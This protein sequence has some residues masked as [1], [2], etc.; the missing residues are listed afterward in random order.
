MTKT[1]LRI[2]ACLFVALPIPARA[3]VPVDCVDRAD[4]VNAFRASNG[5]GPFEREWAAYEERVRTSRKGDPLYVPKPYPKEVSDVAEDFRYAFFERLFP[6]PGKL[7]EGESAVYDAVQSDAVTYSLEIVENWTPSRCDS[8][9]PIRRYLLLRMANAQGQEIARAAIHESGVFGQF[10]ILEGPES[11]IA[12][13]DSVVTKVHQALRLTLSNQAQLQRVSVEG[14]PYR[15]SPIMPCTAFRASGRTYVVDHRDLI[16]A[17]APTAPART[18]A[19]LR[20]EGRARGLQPLN[21]GHSETPWI[22]VGFG[23]RQA[24]RV[25]GQPPSP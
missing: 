11:A 12:D 5:R 3:W 8:L 22:S 16:Y 24:T 1:L 15:C 14:L 10:A 4:E 21:V 2:L 23:W 19:Q 25:S 6:E 17:F 20:T 7:S 9:R 18:V 13:L